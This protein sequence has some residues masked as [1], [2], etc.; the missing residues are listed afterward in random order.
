MTLRAQRQPELRSFAEQSLVMN[1]EIVFRRRRLYISADDADAALP[2]C[3]DMHTLRNPHSKYIDLFRYT[4]DI[5]PVKAI[6]TRIASAAIPAIS[7]K[8]MPALKT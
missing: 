1:R 7:R 4:F 2:F 5:P 3:Y 6:A 8:S